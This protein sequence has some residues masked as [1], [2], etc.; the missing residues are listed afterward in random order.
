MDANEIM[1]NE[2]VM[3]VTENIVKAGTGKGFKVAAGVGLVAIVGG[4][5]YKFVIKPAIAKFK[6]KN[7]EADYVE[8]NPV[9]YSEE[10]EE[11]FEPEEN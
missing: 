9:E 1:A 4:L 6:S 10:A 5:A 2:E 3:E 11:E 8:V 7:D